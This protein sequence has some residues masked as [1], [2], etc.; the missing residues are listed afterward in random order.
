MKINGFCIQ[1][2]IHIIQINFWFINLLSKAR[3]QGFKIYF[4]PEF[5]NE[6]DSIFIL[7]SLPICNWSSHAFICQSPLTLDSCTFH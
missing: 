6:R 7:P 3:N 5:G 1:K 4:I 2:W